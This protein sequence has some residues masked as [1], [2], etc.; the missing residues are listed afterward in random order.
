MLYL[1]SNA[2]ATSARLYRESLA[3][4]N[5]NPVEMPSGCSIFPNE[6]MTPSRRWAERRFKSLIYWSEPDKG[7]HFAAMEVPEIFLQEVRGCFGNMQL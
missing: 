4:P 6:I 7:G 1:L 5:V 2:G 3:S